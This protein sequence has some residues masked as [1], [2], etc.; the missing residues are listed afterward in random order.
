VT[1]DYDVEAVSLSAPPSSAVIQSYR[2]AVLVRN[3]GVHDALAIGSLRIYSPAGLLIFTTAIYS[4]VISPGETQPAQA[5]DYWT[6]P[7]LGRFMFIA[8]VSCLRDQY[9]P[10]DNLSPTFVDVGPGEPTPP[11]PVAMHAA[12]HEE[13]GG[14]ELIIDGL[15]GRTADAQTPLGHKATHQVTGSDAISVEGL[16]GILLQPQPIADHK[17]THEHEGGDELWVGGLHGEL[18]DNQKP[19]TH[20]NA[21][22]DPNFATTPHGNAAHD[23]NFA[24]LVDGKVPVALLGGTPKSEKFFLR[25]DQSWQSPSRAIVIGTLPLMKSHP[26][27]AYEVLHGFTPTELTKGATIHAVVHGQCWNESGP[28][29]TSLSV[30]IYARDTGSP[31][32]IEIGASAALTLDPNLR[33]QY[34]IDC[35]IYLVRTNAALHM[36][37]I[38]TLN[39]IIA[40]DQALMHKQAFI[41]P[42]L[43]VFTPSPS[44]PTELSVRVTADDASGTVFGGILNVLHIGDLA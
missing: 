3:N 44:L 40:D 11:T 26:L 31:S 20:D 32:Y 33:L 29:Q 13:G 14:D 23:P 7:A 27:T 18:A 34:T 4:G 12:Q 19:K 8:T 25:A 41:L 10:N 24:G 17:S 43:E 2:P 15:H 5:V 30:N 37:A 22:H 42:H 38:G 9:E 28:A 36:F 16:P 35:Y 6:P 39:G 21:A 1:H